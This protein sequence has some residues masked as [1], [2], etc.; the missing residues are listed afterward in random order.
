[1]EIQLF[2]NENSSQTDAYSLYSNYSYSGLIPNKR[3][4]IVQ[5]VDFNK[6]YPIWVHKTVEIVH[7]IYQETIV[8]CTPL[9]CNHPLRDAQNM[10]AVYCVRDAWYIAYATRRDAKEKALS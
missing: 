9:E 4:L 8:L 10:G 2:R 1:M 3:A 6:L 7:A 5:H